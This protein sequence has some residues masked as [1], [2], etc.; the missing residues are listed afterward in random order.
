MRSRERERFF[1]DG[2]LQHRRKKKRKALKAQK[3][4]S[5]GTVRWK[6]EEEE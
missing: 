4:E 6:S 3:E 1:V 5:D 2:D